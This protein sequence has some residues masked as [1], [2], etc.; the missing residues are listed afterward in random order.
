MM[1]NRPGFQTSPLAKAI[2]A[3]NENTLLAWTISHLDGVER[4]KSV[5]DY[6]KKRA[7]VH[8]ELA[9]YPLHLLKR[10]EG[11]QNG[12]AEME[13]IDHLVHHVTAII[14]A[15]QAHYIPE[16]VIVTDFWYK[17]EIADGN[18]RHEALVHSGFTNYWTIFLLTKNESVKTLNLPH[19]NH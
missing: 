19:R 9:D 3:Q 10:I 5:A 4:N 6:I 17:I 1:Q 11:K 2:A 18:H 14:R 15:I 7:L 8:V 12:E 16:P 13:S